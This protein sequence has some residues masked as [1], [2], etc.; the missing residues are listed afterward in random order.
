MN[1]VYEPINW[2]N[3]EIGGTALG[4]QNLNKMDS[5]LNEIDNRV[6]EM[7]SA[8]MNRADFRNG[9]TVEITETNG[10]VS[11]EVIKG[12][13]TDEHIEAHY[14]ANIQSE[15]NKA[16]TASANAQASEEKATSEAQTAKDY[17]DNT[18]NLLDQV[19][20]RLNI[21]DF[22]LDDEGD[23]I[24]TDN[25]AYR[26]ELGDDGVLCYEIIAE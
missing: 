19:N 23:L 17:N 18:K 4:E 13:I 8:K 11:A 21:V 20:K 5:A 2:Q 7:D 24:Y 1:K 12:S 6:V 22:E 9:E 26:F 15:A 25:E 14:L 16:E 10:K 3:G